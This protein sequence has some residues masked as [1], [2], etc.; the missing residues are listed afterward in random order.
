MAS[1]L[2]TLLLALLAVAAGGGNTQAQETT[3]A[4]AIL[5]GGCFWCI[6]ADFLKLDGVVDAVSG[7]TGG[8]FDSPTYQTYN[9]PKAGQ[10]PH[11][12]ALEVTY[13]PA[14]LTY[15]QVLDYYFRHI[16]PT[17]G[18]GQFCDRGAGYRP[19]IFVESDAER[20]AA[21]AKRTEVAQLLNL[22]VRVDILPATRFWPAEDYHQNYHLKNP[23]RYKYYRWNCGRDQRVQQ[24]WGG[25]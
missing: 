24:L 16:D 1:K 7:Y 11:V 5:A 13:D 4:K 17:D 12:E 2:K 3:M 6:Q 23:V 21:T 19:V 14:K 9:K 20:V 10:T 18:D 15:A 25:K 22:P 8:S